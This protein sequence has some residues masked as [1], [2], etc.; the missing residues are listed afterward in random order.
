M[1]WV[2]RV[3]LGRAA[4][5]ACVVPA[6]SVGAVRAG[7]RHVGDTVACSIPLTAPIAEEK[8]TQVLVLATP[9]SCNAG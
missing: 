5:V 2:R 8:R 4:A 9:S 6:G 7:E 1:T 3:C